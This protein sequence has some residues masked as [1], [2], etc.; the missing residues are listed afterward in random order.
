MSE[1]NL[2]CPD[3]SRGLVDDRSFGSTK[4]VGP[5][6]FRSQSNRFDPLIDR[7]TSKFKPGEQ[8]I[9]CILRDLKLN[10]SSCLAL[11][12]RRSFP[13]V[14]TANQIADDQ[15]D[16]IAAAKLAV[17]CQVEQRPVSDTLF[18]DRGRSGSPRSVS[19]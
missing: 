5:I 2:D 6:F 9:S 16:D 19:E 11:G 4:R 17:D 13:D 7:S 18:P 15:L 14:W 1:Q 10:R 12:D 3:V 8:A